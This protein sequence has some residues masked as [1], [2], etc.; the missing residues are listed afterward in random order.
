M[1]RKALSVRLS[2]TWSRALARFDEDNLE[3]YA[4]LVPAMALAAQAGLSQ[5]VAEAVTIRTSRAAP[6]LVA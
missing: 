1:V 6:T 5:L 4:G 2:H 3:S